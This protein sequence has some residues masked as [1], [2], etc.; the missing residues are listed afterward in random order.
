VTTRTSRSAVAALAVLVGT[1][2]LGA[3]SPLFGSGGSP[4]LA[5]PS[6]GVSVVASVAVLAAAVVLAGGALAVL[7]PGHRWRRPPDEPVPR[8]EAVRPTW[9]ARLAMVAVPAATLVAVVLIAG[10]V[11]GQPG[12]SGG[13]RTVPTPPARHAPQA[14]RHPSGSPPAGVVAGAGGALVL[15]L[16]WLA[17][18]AGT[19]RSRKPAAV[20]SRAPSGGATAGADPAEEAGQP[21]EAARDARTAVLHAYGA[22]TAKL[23]RIDLGRAR[24]EGPRE[25]LARVVPLLEGCAADAQR[26]ERL[27]EVARFTS[28]PLDDADRL[29][30]TTALRRLGEAL[31]SRPT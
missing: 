20:A 9:A 12:N 6:G 28:R 7:L 11:A 5:L 27:F 26:V 17:W 8:P 23:A 10:W 13:D 22:M 25:H 1:A 18:L 15:S 21:L 2:A 31:R 4:S 24:T 3:R 29:E 16:L 30:A 14:P 19:R